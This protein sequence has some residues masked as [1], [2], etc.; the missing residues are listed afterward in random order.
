M[1]RNLQ[2]HFTSEY[3]EGISVDACDTGLHPVCVDGN[4]EKQARRVICFP[5]ASEMS[6]K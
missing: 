4:L 6:P 2:L 3:K 1:D 5:T